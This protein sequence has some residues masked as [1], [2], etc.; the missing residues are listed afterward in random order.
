MSSGSQCTEEGPFFPTSPR[1]IVQNGIA[2]KEDILQTPDWIIIIILIVVVVVCLIIIIIALV[3]NISYLNITLILY[4]NN[5][6]GN[7]N[8]RLILNNV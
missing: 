8:T 7:Y 3:R 6:L 2:V 1:S 5:F 4:L